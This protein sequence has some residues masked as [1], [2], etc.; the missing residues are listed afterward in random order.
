MKAVNID[1]IE[2]LH[3]D[4][5]DMLEMTDEIQDVMGRSYDVNQNVDESELLDELN[6]LEDTIDADVESE[7]ATVAQADGEAVAA[8]TP[9]YLVSAAAATNKVTATAAAPAAAA[10]GGAGGSA[11]PARAMVA[12][13]AGGGGGG[14]AGGAGAA[15]AGGAAKY[16]PAALPSVPTRKLME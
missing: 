8:E 2:D 16:D 9:N 6:S 14:A 5:S 15:G 4:M 13:K 10:A 11:A 12:M 1:D 3:D 7:S